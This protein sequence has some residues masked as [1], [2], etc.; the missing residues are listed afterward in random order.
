[1]RK[2][3]YF[4]IAVFAVVLVVAL[5]L[6]FYSPNQLSM[7]V[8]I[9]K[10]GAS[11]S[12]I[13]PEQEIFFNVSV[14]NTGQTQISKLGVD[15]LVNGNITNVYDVSVPPGKEGYA[16]INYTVPAS[17]DYNVTVVAD[18]GRLYDIPDRQTTTASV[19][20]YVSAIEA[21]DAYLSLPEG[22]ATEVGTANLATLGF[23]WYEYLSQNY[24]ISRFNV[25][26]MPGLAAFGTALDYVGSYTENISVAHATYANGSVAYS[27]WLNPGT[28]RDILPDGIIGIAAE[29]LNLS[30]QNYT[31]GGNNVQL[32]RLLYNE[33]LCSW[34]SEGW[35][36]TVT[37]NSA[38][39]C[40]GMVND[41]AAQ[42]APAAISGAKDI[43]PLISGFII[44][45]DTVRTG[46]VISEGYS[47]IFNQSIDDAS[48]T[49]NLTMNDS[50]AG[51]IN[52]ADNANYCSSFVFPVNGSESSPYLI[53]TRAMLGYYNLTVLW[54]T[55]NSAIVGLIPKAI[56]VADGYNA[57]GTSLAF[58]N[59]IPPQCSISGFE[60]GN[61]TYE[62]GTLSLKLVS[63]DPVDSVKLDSIGCVFLGATVPTELNTT[64]SPLGEDNITTKCYN[65]GQVATGLP[66][67]LTFTLRLNYTVSN[68]LHSE[69]GTVYVLG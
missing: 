3:I 62:N 7:K 31:V 33:S 61:A 20:L 17:G 13:Y 26:G 69:N 66:T 40:L 28:Y 52:T 47:A 29:G 19:S 2:E 49:R 21:P 44:A 6:R 53:R 55:N 8:N 5:Y 35:I 42:F 15:M 51:E 41:S 54:R 24:N 16:L 11:N 50:C 57:T 60:C 30:V 32:V 64:V 10:E 43:P 27:I 18:P 48:L 12:V 65:E 63:L 67:A 4:W 34:N 14:A 46:N 1:M 56:T 25:T 58:H 59:G 38:D 36:K 22:N 23:V 45:N 68:T 9:T 39:G 37:A